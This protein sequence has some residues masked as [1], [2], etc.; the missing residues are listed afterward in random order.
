MEIPGAKT[1]TVVLTPDPDGI[2]INVR[3]PAMPGIFTWG[4]TRGAALAAAREA[5]ELYLEQYI[6]RGEPFPSDRPGHGDAVTIPVLLPEAPPESEDT[7]R[8]AS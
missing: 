5:I 8:A 1:Y 7:Q 3:V 6:E 2:A 4:V